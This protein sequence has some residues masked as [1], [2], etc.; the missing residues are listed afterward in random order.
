MRSRGTN[1]E[2]FKDAAWAR[3]FISSGKSTVKPDDIVTLFSTYKKKREDVLDILREATKVV[4][5]A[6]DLI[7]DDWIIFAKS[8]QGQKIQELSERVTELRNELERTNT[9]VIAK[10]KVDVFAIDANDADKIYSAFKRDSY[11]S[12]RGEISKVLYQFEN[13]RWEIQYTAIHRLTGGVLDSDIRAYRKYISGLHYICQRDAS[14]MFNAEF[15][16][17]YSFLKLIKKSVKLDTI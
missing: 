17:A 16:L 14:E 12:H 6:A 13:A 11:V 8:G 7:S 2:L 5:K 3:I 9:Q 1:G 15:Q 4:N 10:G